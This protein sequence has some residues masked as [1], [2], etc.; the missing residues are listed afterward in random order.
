MSSVLKAVGSVSCSASASIEASK[1]LFRDIKYGKRSQSDA[2]DDVQ[3]EQVKDKLKALDTSKELAADDIHRQAIE[4]SDKEELKNPFSRLIFEGAGNAVMATTE[5]VEDFGSG[6]LIGDVENQAARARVQARRV[7]VAD[8][9]IKLLLTELGNAPRKVVTGR[10]AATFAAMMQFEYGPFHAA[11]QVGDVILEWNA[12]SLVIPRRVGVETPLFQTNLQRHGQW[13]AYIASK[14]S[15]AGPRGVDFVKEIDHVIEVNAEK[16]KI[17]EKL[18]DVILRYNK[19]FHYHVLLRN[20][21]HFVLDAMTALGIIDLPKFS[22][23][24][25]NYFEE[26]LTQK[27]KKGLPSEFTTHADLDRY[28]M[29][30]KE[31]F[32]SEDTEY[33]LCQYICL[34]VA[35]GM[36]D[37]TEDTEWKCPEP[38]CQME[39]LEARVRD[40]DLLLYKYQT[41]P[42][43]AVA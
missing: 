32:T 29:H 12:S 5:E 27:K 22:G 14:C 43:E 17:I 42:G 26:I 18:I 19:K 41:P 15:H 3:L 40:A 6:S 10:P 11:L 36:G 1:Q 25:R 31:Q 34:H 4:L 7:S 21:Q 8:L 20:C 28:V 13:A 23:R 35:A 37:D 33:F 39:T 30:H 16:E 38:G 24:L 9:P 2:V